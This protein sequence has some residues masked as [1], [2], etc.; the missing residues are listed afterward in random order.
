MVSDIFMW[1]VRLNGVATMIGMVGLAVA[2]AV[3]VVLLARCVYIVV[4]YLLL[5]K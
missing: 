2:G 1:Q 5:L 4:L 3:L